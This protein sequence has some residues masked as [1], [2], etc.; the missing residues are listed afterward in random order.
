MT[1][2]KCEQGRG[3]KV[4]S[5]KQRCTSLCPVDCKGLRVQQEH[6]HTQYPRAVSVQRLEHPLREK[7]EMWR[8]RGGG[9]G[10]RMRVGG[11]GV[12][13]E[14]WPGD[15]SWEKVG[16]GVRGGVGEPKELVWEDREIER[17]RNE[18]GKL[19]GKEEGRDRKERQWQVGAGWALTH[20]DRDCHEPW[21]LFERVSAQSPLVGF[22]VLHRSAINCCEVYLE[23]R[24]FTPFTVF[25][26][27]VKRH[28]GDFHHIATN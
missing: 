24:V 16:G 14:R 25:T 15:P 22:R 27:T 19:G 13:R 6:F 28:P 8:G 3:S 2:L 10:G 5:L 11:G 1:S 4:P 12:E 20:A 21:P 26:P 23:M 7:E 18:E 9:R 17:G